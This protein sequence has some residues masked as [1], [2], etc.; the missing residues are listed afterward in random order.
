MIN[1]L[2]FCV[3]KLYFLKKT[4]ANEQFGTGT[5]SRPCWIKCKTIKQNFDGTECIFFEYWPELRHYNECFS[6]S[7]FCM[8]HH[9][10]LP[11]I[12]WSINQSIL[13]VLNSVI[14]WLKWIEWYKL[15]SIAQYRR[16]G[17]YV[18]TRMRLDIFG[19]Q[20]IDPY[21]HHH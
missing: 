12:S 9:G 3:K 14:A 18:E 21:F 10:S 17:V 5:K 8:F 6:V 15:F 7:K 13:C 20:N 1:F 19:H 2:Y 4:S 16:V 11:I